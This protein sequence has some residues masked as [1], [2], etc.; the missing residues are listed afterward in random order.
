MSATV[1]NPPT[2]ALG[3][4]RQNGYVVGDLGRAIAHWTRT[5]GVGPFFTIADQP[6][7]AFTYRGTPSSP[8][9][10][11]ALAYSGALQI[12]LIQPLDDAPSMWRD[13]LEAGREG[14]HHVA[15]WTTAY[16]DALATLRAGGLAVAQ[17]GRSG[18]GGPNERFSYL[19]D[20]AGGLV[21]ELSESGATK[22][23][24]Y[25]LVAEAAAAWDGRDPVRTL[26]PAALAVAS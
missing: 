26:D 3:V 25:T 7:K 16:D 19:E 14:L 15:F 11:V 12:E 21:V 22:A 8:R 4:V 13:A 10:A 17:D 9:V 6:I 1:F 20:G 18:A 5:L 24:I 2:A 23:R